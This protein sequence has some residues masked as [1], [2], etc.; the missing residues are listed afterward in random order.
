ML[1]KWN[2]FLIHFDLFYFHATNK[3]IK[4][5]KNKEPNV[6]VQTFEI[7]C[8]QS[9]AL[10]DS[11]ADGVRRD[12]CAAFNRH[13]CVAF[14]KQ[15]VSRLC[16][17]NVAWSASAINCS[18]LKLMR[19]ISS[20]SRTNRISSATEWLVSRGKWFRFYQ[21]I[22]SLFAYWLKATTGWTLP[23]SDS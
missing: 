5:V 6:N 3:Y 18:K 4:N 10:F 9:R 23:S 17:L 12:G 2:F 1:N 16:Y 14:D 20:Q 11:W 19:V 7:Q 13:L 22:F 21:V 15:L 8:C